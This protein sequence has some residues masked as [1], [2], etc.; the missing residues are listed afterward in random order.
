MIN[1]SFQAFKSLIKYLK[2]RRLNMLLASTFSTLNKI[3]DLAPE[4]L[5][6]IA[7]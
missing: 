1:S 5:I 3:F 2:P 6:C 4:I 7:V